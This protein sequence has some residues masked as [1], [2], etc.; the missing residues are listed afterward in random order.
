MRPVQCHSAAYGTRNYR[1]PEI[2]SSDQL[3]VA[4]QVSHKA[5]IWAVGCILYEMKSRQQFVEGAS[6]PQVVH[7][8][9][10]IL[11]DPTT[12]L[13]WLLM[14]ADWKAPLV[15]MLHNSASQRTWAW[16]PCHA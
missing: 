9:R 12:R 13:S 14:A 4:S 1:A 10:A 16:L 6:S 8:L 11:R 2:Y 15:K 3:V 5:D 7:N